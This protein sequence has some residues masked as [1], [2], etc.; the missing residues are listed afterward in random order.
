M[1]SSP[2]VRSTSRG[3][4]K[5]GAY[6]SIVIG[7][8]SGWVGGAVGIMATHPLDSIRVVKQYQARVCKNNVRYHDIIMHIRYVH[9]VSGFYR[10]VIPPT[11]LRG[12]GVSANRA[13][14]NLGLHLFKDEKIHGT[15]RIWVVG[16]LAGCCSG[17]VDMP[18]QLLKCRAQV[19]IGLTKETFSLYINMAKRIWKYEGFR[20]FT[21]GFI[22]QLLYNAISFALFYAIYDHIISHGFSP[23]VAGMTAGVV[24]WPPVLPLDSLR[25]RMQCQPVTVGLST[26]VGQ[27]WRQPV[28]LW[29]TGLGVTVLRAAPRWGITMLAVENCNKIL[30]EISSE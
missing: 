24:S 21:N 15:W 7:F 13:G 11:V 28:R 25:V 14:Y 12:L 3:P 1:T 10:G 27:M 22:P 30:K 19:R 2:S 16:S 20:A 4:I 26:V 18:V 8:L 9:G 6:Q 23:F 29:F 17:V 5:N